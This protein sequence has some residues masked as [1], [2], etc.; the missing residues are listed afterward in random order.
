MCVGPRFRP[1][2]RFIF[3]P[4]YFADKHFR[5]LNAAATLSQKSQWWQSRGERLK[6]GTR[7]CIRE[8]PR[9]RCAFQ[10]RDASIDCKLNRFFFFFPPFSML[11]NVT[12]ARK[13]RLIGMPLARLP[14]ADSG[15]AS[16]ARGNE[17]NNCALPLLRAQNPAGTHGGFPFP[18]HWRSLPRC[19]PHVVLA[20]PTS[21]LGKSAGLETWIWS[22][23]LAQPCSAAARKRSHRGNQ[24]QCRASS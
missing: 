12:E 24:V 8:R 14:A 11:R 20:P 19:Q 10:P 2:R 4:C 23:K 13:S 22:P 1:N 5:K 15:S 17:Q 6:Q 18:F 16:Q 21:E 3:P 9:P 7:S